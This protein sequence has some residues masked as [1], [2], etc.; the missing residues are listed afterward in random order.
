MVNLM[1]VELWRAKWRRSIIGKETVFTEVKNQGQR[2]I[3][4]QWVV[5]EKMKEGKVICKGQCGKIRETN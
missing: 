1:M 5:T 2:A 3:N 4:T